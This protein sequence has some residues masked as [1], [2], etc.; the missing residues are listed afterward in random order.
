[1]LLLEGD[2]NSDAGKASSMSKSPT[3]NLYKSESNI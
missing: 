3:T 2:V 1:M